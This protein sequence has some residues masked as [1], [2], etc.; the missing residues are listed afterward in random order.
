MKKYE[1]TSHSVG[2]AL[3]FEMHQELQS[4]RLLEN[5][6]NVEEYISFISKEKR[7][8][9]QPENLVIGHIYFPI[10]LQAAPV[11]EIILLKYAKYPAK[12]ID[13]TS[14]KFYF[15]SNDRIIDF[16]LSRKVGDGLLES[17]IYSSSDDQHHFMSVL[18]LKFPS[19]TIRLNKV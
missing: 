10:G 9:F 7:H 12:Y 16:P 2:D 1:F 18:K 15:R 17:L 11:G 5:T 13:N 4:R 3:I 14:G 8:T 6:H 19:W